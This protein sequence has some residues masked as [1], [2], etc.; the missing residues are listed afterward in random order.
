MNP[1][2][3]FKNKR[4]PIRSAVTKLITKIQ[5]YI[6]NNSDDVDNILE[7]QDQLI[8]KELSLKQL[9][10]EME[11]LIV[12]VSEFNAEMNASEEC[13]EKIVSI[14]YKIKSYIKRRE[15]NLNVSNSHKYGQ[16]K[17]DH[18]NQ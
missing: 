5:N 11:I 15:C 18:S 10:S 13:S 16:I 6:E 1:I 7:L 2:E 14:K 4:A 8:E 3:N 12:D 9:N 17:T